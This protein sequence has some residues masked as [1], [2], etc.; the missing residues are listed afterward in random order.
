LTVAAD[1]LIVRPVP[2]HGCDLVPVGRGM[3]MTFAD[4][5]D[6]GA[7]QVTLMERVLL[8]ETT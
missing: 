4:A 5:V 1:S 8:P 3:V 2:R 7:I 6:P